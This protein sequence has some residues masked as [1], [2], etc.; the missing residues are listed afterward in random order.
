MTDY[1]LPLAF[2]DPALLHVL[3]GCADSFAAKSNWMRERPVAVKH[4]NEAIAI[5]NHRLAD[6]TC[7]ASDETLVVIATMAIMEAS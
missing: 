4:L 5:V 1:W 6:D 3:L 2:K 7:L